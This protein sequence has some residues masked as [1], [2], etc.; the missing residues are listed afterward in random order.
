[1]ESRTPDLLHAMQALYQLSYD[2]NEAEKLIQ[3]LV[4][5]KGFHSELRGFFSRAN[6]D[7]NPKMRLGC[8]RRVWG[9]P[10]G[11]AL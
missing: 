2:P 8:R 11:I 6:P 7:K 5:N 4:S 9:R 10:Q 1:M 3:A